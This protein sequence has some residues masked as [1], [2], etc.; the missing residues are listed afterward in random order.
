VGP[1]LEF[2]KRLIGKNPHVALACGGIVVFI[3]SFVA[4]SNV[5]RILASFG[6]YLANHNWLMLT[7]GIAQL[8]SLA[9]G[10]IMVGGA[11]LWGMRR[12]R[13]KD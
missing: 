9:L 3:A 7:V 6:V 8:S 11:I 13:S 4:A 1:M 5:N 10:V 12:R 2:A